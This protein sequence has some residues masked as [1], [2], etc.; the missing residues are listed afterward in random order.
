MPMSSPKSSKRTYSDTGL[1]SPLMNKLDNFVPMVS[2]GASKSS[3][4]TKQYSETAGNSTFEPK[5]PTLMMQ[6]SSTSNFAEPSAAVTPS[7][8]DSSNKRTKLTASGKE[9][10]R[11]EKE[12]KEKEKAEQKAKKEEEKIRREREKEGDRIRK[13][14]EKAKKE[15]EKQARQAEKERKR[16]EK[17]EQNKLKDE[18]KRK[19]EEEK[20]KKNKSQLRLN[21]F[22]PRPSLTDDG[23]TPSPT[24]GSQSPANSRRSSITSLN[25]TNGVIRDRSISTTPSKPKTSDYDRLFPS[26]FLQSYTVLAPCNRFERDEGGL[27][28]ARRGLDEKLASDMATTSVTDPFDPKEMLHLSPYKRRKLNKSQPSVKSIVEQ[29][30]GTLQNPIDLTGLQTPKAPHQPLDLMKSVSTRILK[31]AEDVRPPY[32]GT[33]TKVQSPSVARKICR[34]PFSWDLPS[35]DYDYDSEAEW[36]DPGEGEDLDSEG[37]EEVESEDGDEMEGFL[38]DED[39]P[40]GTK[41]LQKRRILTSDLEPTSTGLCWEDSHGHLVL[42][43]LAQYRLEVI[44]DNPRTFVD[45]Y[46]TAYWLETASTSTQASS[47]RTSQSTMDPPRIP[48]NA[49]NRTNLLMP[50]PTMA[51][52]GVKPQPLNM[53]SSVPPK[54]PQAPKRMVTPDV[55]EDFKRAVEGS[56]LTKAGLIEIL[57][58]QFPKQSKDAIK[59]TLSVVAE[60]VGS[61]EKDKRWVIRD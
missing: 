33:Y 55:L 19:K 4:D 37:E 45:P 11:L 30:H 20:D 47:S 56:D 1:E 14:H 22:F 52:D 48:L 8:P 60:R 10:K 31:F 42:P 44:L 35:T 39:A 3:S 40:D 27:Q 29:L 53:K 59:D 23:S 21:A 51:L 38:D 2:Q 58:K 61:R 15:E 50:N 32:I 41:L 18:E 25:D 34:N 17:E 43:D 36:E 49:T 26:F 9:A 12:A 46:S 6:S 16:Q 54:G 24:R 13:E 5:P 57:K 28:Y 7:T